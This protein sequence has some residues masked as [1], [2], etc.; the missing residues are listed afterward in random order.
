MVGA[1]TNGREKRNLTDSERQA[2]LQTLLKKANDL[3]LPKGTIESTATELKVSG[4]TVSRIWNV[5]KRSY[6]K[7][8][9]AADVSSKIKQNSGRKKQDRTEILEGFN[10]QVFLSVRH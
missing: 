6:A 5:A 10:K 9:K 4:A 8:E 2:V 3:K 1:G 7:G